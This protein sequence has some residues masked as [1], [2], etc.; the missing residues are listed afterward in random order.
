MKMLKSLIHRFGRWYCKELCRREYESQQLGKINE[1]PVEYRFIFQALSSI[2]PKTVLDIGTGITSLPHL[3][4]CCGFIVT[5][6]DNIYDFWPECM[7]NRHFYVINDDITNTHITRK[8]DFITCVS[9]LE[10]IQNHEAAIQSMFAL[11]NPGGHL[12]M[13]FPYNESTYIENV[14]RLPK[15]GYGLEES[16]ICQV[17]SRNELDKWLKI[18]GGGQVVSQEYWQ[19]FTGDFWTFG[20]HIYPFRQVYKC[21]K[22]QLTCVL[23]Q[24]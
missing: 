10:H 15:A 24:K 9:V 8:F 17:Y 14:Y 12:A 5:A 16:Y 7:F 6:I 2:A 1:R 11:L 22:H 13:T 3:M 23:I 18:S 21:D 4:R 20:E 19:I